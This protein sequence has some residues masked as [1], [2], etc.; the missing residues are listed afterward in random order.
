M[1]KK[2]FVLSDC[3]LKGDEYLTYDRL[4]AFNT[5]SPHIPEHSDNTFVIL[6]SGA[7]HLDKAKKSMDAIYIAQLMSFYRVHGV[8]PNTYC[9]APDVVGSAKKSMEQYAQYNSLALNI[10]LVPVLQLPRKQVDLTLLKKQCEFYTVYKP[11]MLAF[12]NNFGRA[13]FS[14][15]PSLQS[16]HKLIRYY[17][18]NTW[19]HVLGAGY[20][21]QDAVNWLQIGFNSCDSLSYFISAQAK[22]AWR[23]NSHEHDIVDWDKQT[24]A[25]H[26][27]RVTNECVSTLVA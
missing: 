6:D 19:I 21:C 11:K 24:I 5:K 22:E 26:N 18:D 17:F 2:S 1:R 16:A 3:G 20:D 4:Y 13:E 12:A 14:N 7:F 10:N 23:S 25:L 27:A 9:I 15:T 8:N